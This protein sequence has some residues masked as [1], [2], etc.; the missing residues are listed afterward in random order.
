VSTWTKCSGPASTG[1]DS[2]GQIS[3]PRGL[4]LATSPKRREVIRNLALSLWASGHKNPVL[5]VGDNDLRVRSPRGGR[6]G[7]ATCP[8]GLS[9]QG[10]LPRAWTPADRSR[11]PVGWSWNPTCGSRTSRRP[12]PSS[13]SGRSDPVPRS[14]RGPEPP[15][16]P[17][18]R[19]SAPCSDRGPESPR[20]PVGAAADLRVR[21][22][23]VSH[24]RKPSGGSQPAC[25]IKCWRRRRALSEQGMGHPLTGWTGTNDNTV[26]PPVTEAARQLPR[27]ALK[28]QHRAH[29]Q[30]VMM[31]SY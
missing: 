23:H 11:T 22:R 30:R 28:T 24:R 20:V 15:R 2:R 1:P 21:C 13:Q 25:R 26:S 19:A 17:Q 12:E 3:N 16:V 7:A 8:P 31:I 9:A 6:S 10:R 29:G 18:V 5:T 4:V 27:Q 14:G